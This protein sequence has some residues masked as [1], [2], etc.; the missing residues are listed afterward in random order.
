MIEPQDTISIPIAYIETFVMTF[1]A[2]IIGYIGAT[3]YARIRLKKAKNRH[4]IN[5]KH[6]HTTIKNLKEELDQKA[7]SIFRKDRMN[8]DYDNVH[9]RARAFSNEVISEKV[10]SSTSI[11]EE[12]EPLIE[13][14][15]I[16]S[17]T[18]KDRNNLQLI[19][20]IGPYTEAKL[21]EL[22]IYTFEQISRFTNEDIKTVTKLIKF[23]PDRIKN[24]RWV[25]KAKRLK[26]IDL[27]DGIG[28]DLKKKMT[29][30]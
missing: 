27:H 11:S 9:V 10:A 7:D 28:P 4:L 30:K 29:D 26:N 25:E 6:L 18:V 22:G 14:S 17:A 21:N 16:G 8:Q 12:K 3:I 5:T 15:R 20:G 19:T 1:G 24:D 13:F 23:F 2:F